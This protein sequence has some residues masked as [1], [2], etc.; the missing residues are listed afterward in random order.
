MT[1]L[2]GTDVARV[3][4]AA[5]DALIVCDAAGVIVYANEQAS[6]TFA[7]GPDELIGSSVEALVPDNARAVHAAHRADYAKE[8][9][10]R[11]MAERSSLFARRADGSSFPVEVALSPVTLA[12]EPLVVAV[13]RDVTVRLAN[14]D[15]RQRAAS[16]ARASQ[17]LIEER[18]RVARELHDTVIQQLFAAGLSLEATAG[19]VEE[20]VRA[21]VTEAV[22]A[23]DGSIRQL[24][25]SI[26]ALSSR[27]EGR[28]LR[29]EL[30]VLAAEAARFLP[31]A[32]R[33][34]IS[35]EVAERVPAD[36]GAEVV[37]VVRE[38][39]SN[40]VR[41][42]RA[43]Q[44]SVAIDIERTD[45]APAAEQLSITVSDDGVGVVSRRTSGGRGL[46]NLEQRAAR[47]NGSMSIVSETPAGTTVTW[48]A[49]IPSG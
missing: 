41:H 10:R 5:P 33:L 47:L 24:R 18:E 14:D 8:P 13:A 30:H 39:L 29:S 22:D 35:P 40:T 38:C 12:G 34:A 44:V 48:R 4:D 19:M 15:E 45:S 43:S 32:P 1:D 28:D 20:P 25:A 42:S 27:R 31:T 46:H 11:S 17:A 36:L 23:I 2:K 21:R 6:V 3:L 7:A 37:A 26:F 9:T 49:P 16:H